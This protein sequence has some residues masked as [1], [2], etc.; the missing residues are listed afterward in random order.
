MPHI[1][2]GVV[3]FDATESFD[4]D[5]CDELTFEWDFDGDGIFGEPVDDSYTGPDDNPTHTYADDYN[6]PVILRLTDSDG[7][8]AIC[9]VI[10]LVI[11]E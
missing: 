8:I 11:V 1:G 10:V 5:P 6:G 4:P 3:E 7:L 9:V 2:D